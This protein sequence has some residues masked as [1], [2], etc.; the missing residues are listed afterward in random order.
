LGVPQNDRVR[1]NGPNDRCLQFHDRVATH[2]APNL[3]SLVIDKCQH[4]F[5]RNPLL[6]VGLI[7]GFIER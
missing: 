3:L 2:H 6:G 5:H 4:H 1:P 7:D